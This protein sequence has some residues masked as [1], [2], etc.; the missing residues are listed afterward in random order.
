MLEIRQNVLVPLRDLLGLRG[1]RNIQ[2]AI[3]EGPL[4]PNLDVG[5]IVQEGLGR[6]FRFA[7]LHISGGGGQAFKTMNL[8]DD[9]NWDG[10]QER[11]ASGGAAVP[12]EHD[13]YI[14]SAQLN[15]TA[16]VLTTSSVSATTVISGTEYPR[17]IAFW[18]QTEEWKAGEFIGI[19]AQRD[20]VNKLPA[21]LPGSP[22]EQDLEW[23]V[24]LSAGGNA[25]LMLEVFSA[26][27]GAIPKVR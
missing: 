25:L 1:S 6:F 22:V 21:L 10:I 27:P 13:A 26:P 15:L 2:S 17:P 8:R 23:A 12:P 20:V 7:K 11:G 18:N 14:L 5:T 3:D 24:D 19:A 16:D 9:S 4:V